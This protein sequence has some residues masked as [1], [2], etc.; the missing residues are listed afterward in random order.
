V[1]TVTAIGRTLDEAAERAYRA[2]D[3][4]T[5]EGKMLRRDIGWRARTA[6]APR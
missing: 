6:T 3:A 5:F 1:L 2:A 4:I